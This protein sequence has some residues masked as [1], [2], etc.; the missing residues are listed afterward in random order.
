MVV[1]RLAARE[2]V[3]P[4]PGIGY[5]EACV[6]ASISEALREATAGC[7]LVMPLGNPQVVGAAAL[8]GAVGIVMCSGATVETEAVARA[9]REGVA[10]Y[11][12][13]VAMEDCCRLLSDGRDDT[14]AAAAAGE[15]GAGAPE[16]AI[17]EASVPVLGDAYLMA[18]YASRRVRQ[19]LS[20]AGIGG[21]LLRRVSIATYEAEMNVVI[22][23]ADGSGRVSVR[24]TPHEVKVCVC[25]NGPGIADVEAAMRPGYSTAHDR[26]RAMGFGAGMGLPNMVS[27]CDCLAIEGNEGGGTRVEMR[28]RRPGEAEA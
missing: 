9:Q 26:A 18:G 14:P 28:F 12:T 16:G 15:D 21:E 8:L 1:A 17:A 7:L 22:H 6:A 2:L 23:A 24:L 13:A 5:R 11:A 4:A 27:C 25:D 20:S 19:V 3:P 10:L